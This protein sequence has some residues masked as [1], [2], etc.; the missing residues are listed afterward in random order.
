MGAKTRG[1][2]AVSICLR[3]CKNRNKKCDKCIKFS[4]YVPIKA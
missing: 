2:Y 3:K 1:N 4:K